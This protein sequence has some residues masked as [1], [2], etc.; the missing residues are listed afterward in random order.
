MII[1]GKKINFLGDSI[2][3]GV[4][5]SSPEYSYVNVFQAK[6][7]PS[8]VRNYGISASCIA[9]T[10]HP[11]PDNPPYERYFASRVSEMDADADV[12]VVFGGVNDFVR[13][14]APLGQFEDRTADT[15]YGACHE[16]MRS[17]IERFP[18]ATIVFITPLHNVGAP[19]NKIGMPTPQIKYIQAIRETAE[20]YSLPI[21]DLYGMGGIQP[22]LAVHRTHL[23]PDAVHPNNSGAERIADRLAAF[24]TTL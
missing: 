3:E 1:K 19:R 16:L 24:L 13:G 5:V 21:F 9:K 23:I 11:A 8:L 6:Y 2:T 22:G 20:Y 18:T 12:V 14:D 7:E 17:L 10:H 4:G 15:F